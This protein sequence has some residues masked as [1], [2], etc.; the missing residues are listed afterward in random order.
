MFRA[1][2]QEDLL[3]G[4]AAQSFNIQQRGAGDDEAHAVRSALDIFAAY[5]QTVAVNGDHRESAAL[6]FK[7]AAHVYR[8]ALVCGDGEYALVYHA[9]KHLLRDADSF[10]DVDFGQFG[11]IGRGQSHEAVLTLAAF[12]ARAA[13]VADLDGDYAVRQQ[14]HH[15]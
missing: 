7:E 15:L 4:I 1:D 13:V 11:I 14:A 10:A 3:L 2:V 9:A 8:A 5:G 12:Y 6:E